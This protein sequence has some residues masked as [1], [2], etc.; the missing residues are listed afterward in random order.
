[1]GAGA[2]AGRHRPPE[3]LAVLGE[4]ESLLVSA[5]ASAARPR[6]GGRSPS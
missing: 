5:R 2:L 1:M 6:S 4:I 3:A